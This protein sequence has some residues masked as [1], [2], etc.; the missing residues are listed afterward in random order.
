LAS[1]TISDTRRSART[2]GIGLILI[3]AL[4]G[5]INA[6]ITHALAD[7]DVE[8]VRI[9]Q[10]RF[11]V[12]FLV[13]AGALAA[14]RPHV[15]RVP[16]VAGPKLLVAGLLTAFGTGLG[17]IVAISR[18]QIGPALALVY[19]SPLMLLTI[20]AVRA[21]R[22]PPPAAIV[23]AA[24]VVLGCWLV[25][26][27]ANVDQIDA[28][29]VGAALFAAAS[30]AGYVT[31]IGDLPVR[32]AEPTIV[33][34]MFG[35]AAVALSLWPPIW[36]FPV[37]RLGPTDWL[38]LVGVMVFATLVPYLTVAGA[39]LRLPGP[40]VGILMTLEPV[41]ATAIAWVTL[42]QALSAL[43]MVGIALVLGAAVLA[44]ARGFAETA[45]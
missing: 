40:L 28:L 41:A 10:F 34:V 5:G 22:V 8:P 44:Q 17:Y 45:A 15:F 23:S 43:Q 25:V 6:S 12:A 29:G 37:D 39:T 32:L 35:I 20:H 18:L 42:G 21:R 1:V 30:F 38:G 26:K 4:C 19:T 13:L 14:T 11:V 3:T 36:T 16:R 24:I 27:A 7:A 2:T 9:N 31:L 33:V